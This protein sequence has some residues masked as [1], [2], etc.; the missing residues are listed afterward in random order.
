MMWKIWV[1]CRY[2]LNFSKYN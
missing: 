2:P 1:L